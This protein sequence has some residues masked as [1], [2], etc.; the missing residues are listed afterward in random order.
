[1]NP[2]PAIPFDQ[3]PPG[4]RVGIRSESLLLA[5]AGDAA[6]RV[7]DVILGEVVSVVCPT[8]GVRLRDVSGGVK[9]E[10]E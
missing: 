5:L 2:A 10:L 7:V 6:E 1:M 8:L 4:A 9:D 3:R